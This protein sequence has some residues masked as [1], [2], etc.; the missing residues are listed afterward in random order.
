[1][2]GNRAGSYDVR[3]DEGKGEQKQYFNV[4]HPNALTGMDSADVFEVSERMNLFIK[5]I[6]YQCG[7][8]SGTA[9]GER[10][11]EVKNL[12]AYKR[13]L[14][15][16]FAEKGIS[17]SAAE[18]YG[19]E[20]DRLLGE[21]LAYFRLLDTEPRL[22]GSDIIRGNIRMGD[23][24]V[25]YRKRQIFE[26]TRFHGLSL[27]GYTPPAADMISGLMS[28]LSAYEGERNRSETLIQSALICYQFLAVMP[29]EEDNL[30]WAGILANAFLRERG[31][32]VGYYIPL[33][34]YFLERDAER[35]ASMGG[36]RQEG[37][38]EI[39]VEFY[40]QVLEE[41]MERT[42][43]FV[44]AAERLHEKSCLA[45]SGEKQRDLLVRMIEYME[46]VP[47]FDIKDIA[48]EFDIVYNTA[49]KMI[50][51]FE[52]RGLVSEISKRQR[53]RLY[54]YDAYVKEIMK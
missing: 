16:C 24:R 50:A 43:R 22:M 2:E 52:K 39:W 10:Q 29:Y 17:M 4:Y 15:A 21:K 7:F 26:M 37:R 11:M 25:A 44:V 13:E 42:K 5:K 32:F 12:Q 40:L 53:Y 47:I 9:A 48:G 51:I 31:L 54:Q 27:R 33:V 3:E 20:P 38:Y 6:Y 41:A 45:V 36:V 49:A 34:R 19:K 8:L 14:A 23:R 18:V 35:K 28:D 46:R 30:L 1:M